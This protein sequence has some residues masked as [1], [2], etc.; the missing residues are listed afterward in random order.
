VLKRIVIYL[1]LVSAAAAQARADSSTVLV[2]PFENL[3]NDH[4]LDW[5]GE[6]IAELIIERL[7]TEPGVY[8]STREERLAGYETLGIPETAMLSRATSLKFGWDA[9]AD[10]VITGSFSGT[11]G[12]LRIAAR[13]VDMEAGA[14]SETNIDGKLED[15]IPL[16]MTLSWQLLR[17]IVPGTASPESDYTARPFPER[18]F[19][20]T[21]TRASL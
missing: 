21:A 8:V 6:G 2:F 16:T 17:K 18:S 9:G 5:I 14:A 15:V 7:Q 10:N 1:A 3:S 12:D 11:A 19:S 4:T 13:L 20:T